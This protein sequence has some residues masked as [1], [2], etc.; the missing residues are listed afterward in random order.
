MSGK[1]STILSQMQNTPF[2]RL[3]CYHSRSTTTIILCFY[4]LTFNYN[5]R[6][7]FCMVWWIR[8]SRITARI[9]IQEALTHI[10][11]IVIWMAKIVSMLQ[12]IYDRKWSKVTHSQCWM[13]WS[14]TSGVLKSQLHLNEREKKNSRILI[15]PICKDLRGKN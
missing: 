11:A 15:G 10:V 7:T 4:N 12:H 9:N 13:T 1:F 8:S 2:V 14:K 6:I 3:S 5:D